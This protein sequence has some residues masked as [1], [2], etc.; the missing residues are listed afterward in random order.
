[1]ID[2]ILGFLPLGGD[3]P[4]LFP[5]VAADHSPSR[6]ISLV[7]LGGQHYA[8]RVLTAKEWMKLPQPRRGELQ[9]Q[10]SVI[11]GPGIWGVLILQPVHPEQI[12]AR[13]ADVEKSFF[14]EG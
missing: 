14:W 2:R 1:V 3:Q 12:A 10:S 13:K 7:R 4:D 8:A 9:S 6:R 5:P 11:V